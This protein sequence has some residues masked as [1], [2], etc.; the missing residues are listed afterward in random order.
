MTT[1]QQPVRDI[2]QIAKHLMIYSYEFVNWTN[3]YGY[4][5]MKSNSSD[6]LKAKRKALKMSKNAQDT[7]L[8]N[9]LK[10]NF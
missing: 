8:Y 2:S 6:Y 5:P 10:N 1:T 9:Y 4:C 3:L 7:E